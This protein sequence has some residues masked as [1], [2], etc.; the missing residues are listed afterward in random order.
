MGSIDVLF[1]HEGWEDITLGILESSE[2]LRHKTSRIN[3][4]LSKSSNAESERRLS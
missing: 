1:K 3:C 2:I 4:G